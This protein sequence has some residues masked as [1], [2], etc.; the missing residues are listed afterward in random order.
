MNTN[1]ELERIIRDWLGERAVEPPRTSLPDAMARVATT[2]QPRRHWLGRWLDRGQGATRR[3]LDRGTVDTDIRRNR[4]MYGMTGLAA[5]TAA[6]TLIAALVVPR[7]DAGPT[8]VPAAGAGATLIVAADGSGEFSTIGDAVAAAA[9]GDTV[10][11]KPGEYVEIV[12]LDKDITLQ[13]DG[14]R[15]SI[16]IVPPTPAPV[17]D[18]GGTLPTLTVKDSNAT[19]R[20]LTVKPPPGWGSILVSGGTPTFEDVAQVVA[21]VPDA[22]GT[23]Y[24]TDGT[25]AVVRNSTWDGFWYVDA[26]ASATLED[27][28][29]WGDAGVADGSV[30]MR[31]NVFTG[32]C[33]QLVTGAQA[34]I[35]ANTFD[36][37]AGDN[38]MPA[39]SVRDDGTTAQIVR[40]TITGMGTGISVLNGAASNIRDNTLVD[41]HLGIG[42]STTRDGAIEGNVISGGIT[43]IVITAGSPAVAD[44]SVTGA[45]KFGISIGSQATP[46]LSGNTL[47]GSR[48]NLYVPAGAAA[49]IGENDICQDAPPSG[50]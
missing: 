22:A 33:L 4:R 12:L 23:F 40:N 34:V 7:G 47:C 20:S 42:W 24:F 44:N 50:G 38:T 5:A 48:T 36:R 13:G 18:E 9:D 26:A 21:G 16:V 17:D 43:G 41:N 14:P 8:S 11:V 27:N 39:I 2:P 49:S 28:E 37:G 45:A 3:A 31:E 32:C 35:E 25:A 15:E 10:L 19:I 1:Q 6:L 30:V 46:A 29:G